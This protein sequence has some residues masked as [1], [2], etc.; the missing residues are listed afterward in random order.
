[1]SNHLFG[2]T[3]GLGKDVGARDNPRIKSGDGHGG[4]EVMRAHRRALFLARPRHTQ[5]RDRK[6]RERPVCQF[7]KRLAAAFQRHPLT[8]PRCFAL[9]HFSISRP[10]KRPPGDGNHHGGLTQARGDHQGGAWAGNARCI[11]RASPIFA[12]G[13]LIRRARGGGCGQTMNT[14]LGTQETSGKWAQLEAAPSPRRRRDQF[15][16][17]R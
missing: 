12:L 7:R 5:C 11:G 4:G 15:F 10:K 13:A 3:A 6:H 16:P 14:I 8:Q 1:M 2:A 9:I 17:R